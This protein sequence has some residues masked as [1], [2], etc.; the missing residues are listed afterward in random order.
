MIV[1]GEMRNGTFVADRLITK[2]P[3]KYR[4]KQNT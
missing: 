1:E 2:C 3:S 4:A